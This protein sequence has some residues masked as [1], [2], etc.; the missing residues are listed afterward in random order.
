[1]IRGLTIAEK[2]L[3]EQ[4]FGA[5]IGLATVRFLQS[6][7]PFDRAFVAGRW[8]G[9][10]WIVWPGRSL[11]RDIAG[12]PCVSA[13]V[14]C[15]RRLCMGEDENTPMD[16][17]MAPAEEPRAL[18]I[19][20]MEQAK[21]RDAECQ[22]EKKPVLD[23]HLSCLPLIKPKLLVMKSK[24]ARKAFFQQPA[25]KIPGWQAGEKNRRKDGG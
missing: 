13:A 23:D 6:P 8:F 17:G 21:P 14:G 7:W 15:L 12:A 9:R 5:A 4:A 11:P 10:D 16:E 1:M 22:C 18:V 24:E 19:D 20:L 2:A 3:A 25:V